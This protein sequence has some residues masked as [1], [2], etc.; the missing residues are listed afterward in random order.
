[1]NALEHHRERLEAWLRRLP[2]APVWSDVQLVEMP[3]GAPGDAMTRWAAS[4]QGTFTIQ[5]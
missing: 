3:S 4:P 1:M 5:A 2:S